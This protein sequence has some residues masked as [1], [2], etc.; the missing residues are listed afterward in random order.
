MKEFRKD[1]KKSV[2][3]LLE[4]E[5]SRL[6]ILERQKK[7]VRQFLREEIIKE[8]PDQYT[9]YSLNAKIE[10]ITFF[11]EKYNFVYFKFV[12]LLFHHSDS[13]L[14]TLYVETMNE[15][16]EHQ[17]SLVLDMEEQKK[18]AERVRSRY[19]EEQKKASIRNMSTVMQLETD[20]EEE[21]VRFSELLNMVQSLSFSL[22][23]LPNINQYKH[24]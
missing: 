5:D 12:S 19:L 16:K 20:S 11:L 13:E 24:F 21:Q 6:S 14:R 4:R 23:Y 1:L 7:E 9:L 18:H 17:K 10:N 22:D 8:H 2:S 15:L 3:I